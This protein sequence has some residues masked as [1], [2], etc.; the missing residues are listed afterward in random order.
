MA[1]QFPTS[2]PLD[3]APYDGQEPSAWR[4]FGALVRQ[5]CPR[6]C[7]GRIFRGRFEMN[8]PCP[9]CGLLFEREEGYFLGAMYVSYFLAV[10]L[11]GGGYFLGTWLLPDWNP[12]GVIVGVVL[13]YI[14]LTPLIFRIS[15]TVWIHLDRWLAPTGTSAGVYEKARVRDLEEKPCACRRHRSQASR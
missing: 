14:P 10:T 5:R 4:R 8:D 1:S 11:L 13:L 7:Q 9:V 3:R 12:Y 2:D 6:C 15:R